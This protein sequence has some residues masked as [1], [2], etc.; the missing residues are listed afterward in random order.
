[1]TG[2]ISL[3]EDIRGFFSLMLNCLLCDFDFEVPDYLLDYI[4]IVCEESQ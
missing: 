1:M 2:E 3:S 4:L